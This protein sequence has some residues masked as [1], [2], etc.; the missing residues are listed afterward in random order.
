MCVSTSPRL[1]PLWVIRQIS[2][3]VSSW[4]QHQQVSLSAGE[5]RRAWNRWVEHMKGR[6][7][8][9]RCP[10]ETLPRDACNFS[11]R[12]DSKRHGWDVGGM[13]LA[14]ARCASYYQTLGA[15]FWVRIAGVRAISTSCCHCGWWCTICPPSPPHRHRIVRGKP[16]RLTGYL[17]C[18]HHSRCGTVCRCSVY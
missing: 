5:L 15:E 8:T 18:V 16:T 14:P 3:C 9:L 2:N 10:M 1:G 6:L 11:V 13:P 7:E 4:L 12:Y 17:C